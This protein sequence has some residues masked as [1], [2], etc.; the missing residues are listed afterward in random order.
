MCLMMPQGLLQR[1]RQGMA[2][3]LV[4]LGFGTQPCGVGH[5][6][7]QK[8]QLRYSLILACL[9][10]HLSC[11]GCMRC[12]K[13]GFKWK[14]ECILGAGRCFEPCGVIQTWLQMETRMH[15][16]RGPLF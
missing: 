14:L 15:F 13:H 16:G 6:L 11:C 4:K 1:E 8:R 12:Y 2:C 3:P 9:P 10:C 7:H 5:L